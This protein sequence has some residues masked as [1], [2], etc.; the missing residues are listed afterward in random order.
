MKLLKIILAAAAIIAPFK[1][2]SAQSFLTNGLVAYYPFNGNAN[3]MAGTNNGVVYGAA[4]TANRFGLAN[5][6]YAFNGNNAF[7]IVSN[8]SAISSFG[9]QMSVSCWFTMSNNIANNQW[10]G[11]VSKFAASYS[12]PNNGFMVRF[13]WQTASASQLFA[14]MG[15]DAN[16][17]MTNLAWFSQSWV[18]NGTAWYHCVA[19]AASNITW[20]YLNGQLVKQGTNYGNF[21]TTDALTIGGQN[22]AF[23][24]RVFSGKI[25]D[26]RIYNRALSS[27]EVASLYSIESSG[28]NLGIS[29]YNNSPVVFYPTAIGTNYTL[30]MTTN[31]ASPNWVTV[32]NGVPFSGVQITNAPSNAFFQLQ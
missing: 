15:G 30:R 20:L 18:T 4:L 25:D 3:D 8:N 32:T 21:N 23:N 13:L 16:A 12:S 31:L 5:S 6:C 24:G 14:D 27:N 26:V 29:T 22:G 19:V 10:P 7:I 28:P 17:N 1:N 9:N 11:I 2:A